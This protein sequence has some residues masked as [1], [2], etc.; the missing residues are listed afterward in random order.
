MT[1]PSHQPAQQQPTGPIAANGLPAVL[2][3]RA[4]HRWL[5]LIALQLRSR[6]LPEVEVM[7]I[8]TD[9]AATVLADGRPARQVLGKPVAFARQFPKGTSGWRAGRK[10][11]VWLGGPLV[12]LAGV[13]VSNALDGWPLGW[14]LAAVGF[15]GGVAVLGVGQRMDS[16]LPPHLLRGPA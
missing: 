13:S 12:G 2:L 8:L 4:D 1:A 14:G 16:D 5:S 7:R 6:T 9:A 15:A 10:L 11:S 3:T